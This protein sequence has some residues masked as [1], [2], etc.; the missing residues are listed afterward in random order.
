MSRVL[1]IDDDAAM[2]KAIRRVTALSGHMVFE[3]ADGV[4]GLS[5]AGRESPDLIICDLLMPIMDGV[6]TVRL[7]RKE[8]ALSKIPVIILTGVSEKKTVVDVLELGVS[9][10][11]TKPVDFSLL[12]KKIG[13]VLELEQKRRKKKPACSHPNKI[14]RCTRPK[15]VVVICEPNKD[16]MEKIVD[17]L[18]AH[19]ELIKTNDGASCFNAILD[20]CPDAVLIEPEVA[21]LSAFEVAARVKGTPA[22]E[23][24]KILV[25]ATESNKDEVVKY[26]DFLD[27][28]IEE[29]YSTETVLSKV[30]K[31]LKRDHYQLLIEGE[32][33][34]VKFRRGGLKWC[35]ENHAEAMDAIIRLLLDMFESGKSS[36]AFDTTQVG[37]DERG[38]GS[39]VKD[40]VEEASK[41]EAKAV[42]ITNFDDLSSDIKA[43]GYKNVT[44]REK[45]PSGS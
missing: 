27:G 24:T 26:I 34:I 42:V 6:E 11:F 44:V 37:E 16:L 2:R 41:R 29:P 18:Q 23:E 7:I 39:F 5:V 33:L 9:Y 3:A 12:G 28:I 32:E 1:V 40:V 43:K 14:L 15:P 45:A 19:Y 21:F 17:G 20:E 31:L 38:Y 36:I 35:S 22:V 13:Q 30:D 25:F 8:E 10:Y 4:E